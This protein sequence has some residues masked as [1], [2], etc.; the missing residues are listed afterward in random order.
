M[1]IRKEFL[2]EA[3]VR[4]ENEIRENKEGI[5]YMVGENIFLKW[6]NSYKQIQVNDPELTYYIHSSDF[7]Y[8]NL[9]ELPIYLKRDYDIN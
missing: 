7:N 1:I 3:I 8:E 4:I 2:E 6:D 5:S 9:R